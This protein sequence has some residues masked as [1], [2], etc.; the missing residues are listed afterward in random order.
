MADSV[1]KVVKVFL[2]SP[3]DLID[4]RSLAK[5]TV[6]EVNETI[7]RS[8][9]Y[10]IDLIGWE[11]VNPGYGR[12]QGLI[13]KDVE[14]CEYFVGLMW[15]RWGTPPGH[16]D[17]NFTS[18]FEEEFELALQRRTTGPQPEI[19]L[20]FKNIPPERLADPGEGLKQVLN[21]RKRMEAEKRILY[22]TFGDEREY[23][24]KLRRCLFAY[25][26][27][28]K[29][30]D[31]VQPDQQQDRATSSAPDVAKDPEPLSASLFSEKGMRFARSFL[32]LA[33]SVP[34][35][36]TPLEVARFRLLGDVARKFS[37]DERSLGVHDANLIYLGGGPSS[38]DLGEDEL[39]CLADCGFR[40]F[41][42]Q[43]APL[44]R[45]LTFLK[46]DSY[47][48]IT[49]VFGSNEERRGALLAMALI[50]AP[51]WTDGLSLDRPS[52]LNGWFAHDTH[53]SVKAAALAYLSA[54]GIPED[55][56]W[57]RR[58]IERNDFQTRSTAEK[59]I[60]QIRLRQGMPEAVR[61][62]AE[63]QPSDLDEALTKEIFSG[64]TAIDSAALEALISQRGQNVRKAV[65]QIVKRDGLLSS[66]LAHRLLADSDA[67]IRLEALLFLE[68]SGQV[69]SDSE[70]KSALVKPSAGVLH[71]TDYAG[72]RLFADYQVEKY[73][74][75][76][77]E[78]LDE[79][80]ETSSVF[81][82]V[83]YRARAERY[84]ER[85]GPQ[86]RADI[87]DRFARYFHSRL[88]YMEESVG[89]SEKIMSLGD[90]LRKGMTRAAL[91]IL[92]SKMIKDDLAFI[93]RVLDTGAVEYSDKDVAY[94]ARFGDWSDVQRLIAMTARP[95]YGAMSILSYD[96]A[97]MNLRVA[98][99]ILHIGRGNLQGVLELDASAILK[100]MVVDNSSRATFSKL[101]TEFLCKSLRSDDLELRKSLCL[102]CLSA[103]SKARVRKVLSA[104]VAGDQFRYYNVIHW[105]DFGVSMPSSVV[106]QAAKRGF[107]FGSR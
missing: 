82:L 92:C 51:L 48:S 35:E 68:R 14:Q 5:A 39:G 31:A 59:A 64:E 81:D 105:L 3:G 84:F 102:K 52:Y 75:H 20:F 66:E 60:I 76:S 99:A 62:V 16:E 26:E 10:H 61:A 44:W 27:N 89:Q 7:G 67:Q 83:A 97:S 47:M 65:L 85:Y 33:H 24:R 32:D 50:E 77:V 79:K 94:I 30:S 58:E 96:S 12:P 42:H 95:S 106:S 29:V 57:V 55:V 90:F 40:N 22:Q 71:S 53:S 13:N 69:F 6:D 72:E 104:Y 73:K 21:F 93:R 74:K 2:A 78:Q 4:E 101:S 86:L 45:W 15:Q 54:V 17:G 34:S 9:G 56:E 23:L 41:I 70:V 100:K 46:F 1:R 91:D 25:L 87:E 103:F 36:I 63:L 107:D 98:K 38:Q 11:D 8:L 28:L 18:G 80:V 19:S 49:T 37:N 88:S 43:A